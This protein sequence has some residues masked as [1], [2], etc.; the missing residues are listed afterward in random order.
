MA[1]AV[2]VIT[3]GEIKAA[4]A[5]TRGRFA[6]VDT[7]FAPGF[8]GPP[9]HRH[10]E[11]HDCFYVIDGIITA[12]A[13]ASLDAIVHLI[14]PAIALGAIP[15]AIIVRI[16][17]ASVLDVVHEDYVRTAEAKGLYERTITRRH[18]LRNALL[19]V[20]TVIGNSRGR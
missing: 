3:R 4:H 10:R 8:Q 17:R 1:A 5:D 7:V 19:P 6:L 15:L 9:P 2:S 13:E 18:V 16:T 12:N 20:V 14:L 11:M